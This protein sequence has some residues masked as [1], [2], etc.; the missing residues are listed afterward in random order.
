MPIP[1][2][3]S[4]ATTNNN[5]DICKKKSIIGL[6]SIARSFVI[7][8]S[9]AVRSRR[10]RIARIYTSLTTLRTTYSFFPTPPQSVSA[11]EL[12]LSHPGCCQNGTKVCR[13]RALPAKISKTERVTPR[14]VWFHHPPGSR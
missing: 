3:P 4:F 5:G 1:L 9:V 10:I 11:T 8:N 13:R 2:R 6:A 7:Q 14:F 12:I